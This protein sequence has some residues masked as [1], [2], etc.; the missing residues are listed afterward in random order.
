MLI[1]TRQSVALNP[2]M[3]ASSKTSRVHGLVRLSGPPFGSAPAADHEGRRSGYV[4]QVWQWQRTLSDLDPAAAPL[5]RARQV[6][7][8]V[9]HEMMIFETGA[10]GL[11]RGAELL[12]AGLWAEAWVRQLLHELRR[13]I[14]APP[15]KESGAAVERAA[16]GLAE[17]LDWYAARKRSM[18]LAGVE[19]LEGAEEDRLF[20]LRVQ[21]DCNWSG[22]AGLEIECGA[23]LIAR[24]GEPVWL[25]VV[26]TCGGRRIEPRR[27]WETWTDATDNLPACALPRR[28]PMIGLAPLCAAAQRSIIDAVRVFLPYAAFNLAAGRSTVDL[29]VSLSGLRGGRLCVES[30]S[31]PVALPP[32][33]SAAPC[34][35]SPQSLGAW[36]IDAESGSSFSGLRAGFSGGGEKLGVSG[37]L[38]LRGLKGSAVVVECRIFGGPGRGGEGR[39]SAPAARPEGKLLVPQSAVCRL[40]DLSFEMPLSDVRHFSQDG[41][42][43]ALVTAAG[44]GGRRLCGAAVRLPQSLC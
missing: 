30:I 15:A 28:R 16:G 21:H 38:K 39:L 5:Q 32:H 24:A 14:A 17:L 11:E 18:E 37:D 35:P 29:E 44:S 42:S 8:G 4:G 27:G 31:G 12:A 34:V 26:P 3:T 41:P 25:T 6:I 33:K 7:S 1:L 36:P 19:T 22:A 40:Q 20:G 23:I 43:W 13:F 10:A 9:L 2:G